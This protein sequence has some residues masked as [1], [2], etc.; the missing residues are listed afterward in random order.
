MQFAWE[1]PIAK[2]DEFSPLF[3]KHFKIIYGRDKQV[4]PEQIE[5]AKE[6]NTLMF[7]SCRDNG[8]P[9]GYYAVVCN[10]SFYSPDEL[11]AKEIG[12]YVEDDYRG[13]Q[14]ASTMQEVMDMALKEIGAVEIYVS[15]PYETEIPLRAGY[16]FK[17]VTYMRSL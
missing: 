14:V 16:K 12:I 7:L 15:Y 8:K 17:E 2:W 5:R 9:V 13:K 4:S 3:N 6:G 11:I 1:D 10:Q